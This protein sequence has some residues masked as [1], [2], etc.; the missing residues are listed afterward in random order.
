M[1]STILTSTCRLR[2]IGPATLG[3]MA[4]LVA[5]ATAEDRSFDASDE[6]VAELEEAGLTV[7]EFI[8]RASELDMPDDLIEDALADPEQI[9]HVAVDTQTDADLDTA[10]APDTSTQSTC[11]VSTNRLSYYNSLQQE[12]AWFRVTKNWC[13]DGTTV[14]SSDSTQTGDTASWALPWTYNGVL[15]DWNHA[16]GS[17][18]HVSGA[19]G[20]FAVCARLCG[21]RN[22]TVEIVGYGDGNEQLYAVP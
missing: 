2:I 14:T 20:Q 12:L 6:S 10:P 8:E 18:A 3:A 7:D 9:R 16:S 19:Q 22:P 21:E 17:F 1:T 13:Y 5:P 15:D 11:T 4:L